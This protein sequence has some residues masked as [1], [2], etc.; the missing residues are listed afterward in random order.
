MMKTVYAALERHTETIAEKRKELADI[1][2]KMKSG[3]YSQAYIDGELYPKRR[4]LLSEIEREK[5]AATAEA[6]EIVKDYQDQLQRED[7]LKPEEIT[8][9]IE[10]LK[11]GVPLTKRDVMA[12]LER[13]QDNK[14]MTQLALRYADNHGI[15]TGVRY[16]GNQQTIKDAESANYIVHLYVDHWIDRDQAGDVLEKFFG[17]VINE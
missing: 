13:N 12:I 9:D 17:G 1:D 11:S 4:A 7:D 16:R 6:G 3:A 2:S 15:E 10:I 5:D 8:G 14:T